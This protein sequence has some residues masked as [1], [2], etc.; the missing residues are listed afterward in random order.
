[1]TTPAAYVADLRRL[2]RETDMLLATVASLT[3]TEIGQPS[4]CDGWTRG[5]VIT[6]L[7]RSAEALSRMLDNALTGGDRPMYDSP[8]QRNADIEAGAGRPAQEQL[9]DLER[10]HAAFMERAHA[11][12]DAPDAL[13]EV[14]LRGRGYP[15][16]ALAAMRCAEVVIH[17]Q[18]L[19]TAFA[20]HE[21]DPDSQLDALTTVVWMLQGKPDAP[22]LTVTSYEGDELVIG[23]GSL[24]VIGE[25]DG[26]VDWLARGRTSGVRTRGGEALPDLPRW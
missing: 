24:H 15:S 25:R 5:H 8:E 10:A 12:A 1:M 26:L 7:A 9:A 18:D 23:D 16:A 6:H 21:A 22:G 4:Q 14:S 11:L 13:A 19:D 20:L 17:H 2:Q 3:D